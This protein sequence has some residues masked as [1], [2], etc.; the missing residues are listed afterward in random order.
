MS[1]ENPEWE[2]GAACY[3]SLLLS[4][5]VLYYNCTAGCARSGFYEHL[6]SR[7]AAVAVLLSTEHFTLGVY[8]GR[9]PK[10]KSSLGKGRTTT[11]PYVYVFPR[12]QSACTKPPG[13]H[14]TACYSARSHQPRAH[15]CMHIPQA[16]TPI[17]RAVLR[18][19]I[20]ASPYPHYRCARKHPVRTSLRAIRPSAEPPCPRATQEQAVQTSA[21]TAHMHMHMQRKQSAQSVRHGCTVHRLG[22]AMPRA[23]IGHTYRRSERVGLG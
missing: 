3:C 21:H 8:P 23:A 1:R 11:A 17:R 20:S 9:E 14:L 7:G 22:A 5:C 2:G 19:F 4:R 6:G 12:P 16:L 15:T 13:S 18:T 10:L